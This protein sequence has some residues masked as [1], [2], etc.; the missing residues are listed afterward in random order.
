MPYVYPPA[1]TTVVGAGGT[2][3]AILTA[4][5]QTTVQGKLDELEAE[6]ELLAQEGLILEI[7]DEEQTP[8]SRMSSKPVTS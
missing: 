7:L 6:I 1:K 8:V 5:G 4:D 3:D 2:A